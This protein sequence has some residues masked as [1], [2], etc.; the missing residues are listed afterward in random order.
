MKEVAVRYI[1]IGACK[2]EC[3][4]KSSYL[5]S[6]N[7][8]SSQNFKNFY[9]VSKVYSSKLYLRSLETNEPDKIT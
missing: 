6:T 3:K 4:Q 2:Y 1:R 5:K 7:I 8:K 9:I